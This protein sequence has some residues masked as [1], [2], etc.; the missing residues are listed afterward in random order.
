MNATSCAAMSVLQRTSSRPP[1]AAA[2]TQALDVRQR[3]DGEPADAELD[4]VL[5]RRC[6]RQGRCSAEDELAHARDP[7]LEHVRG[8]RDAQRRRAGARQRR[9]RAEGLVAARH[10][11]VAGGRA[12]NPEPQRLVGAAA[13]ARVGAEHRQLRERRPRAAAAPSS[14]TC[15]RPSRR[16]SLSVH[17]TA[18]T[19]SAVVTPATG[20]ASRS[21][22]PKVVV[23]TG[24]P[25]AGT[26]PRA[27]R[28]TRCRH[29]P[30]RRATWR[31]RGR[32]A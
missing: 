16:R 28:S 3:R 32:Q 23:P 11:D 19:P 14:A 1:R 4:R 5:P 18:A 25:A 27:A 26:A 15:S 29:A 31:T 9:A 2:H 7:R 30:R 17:A 20:P 10:D 13:R 6:A 24:P 21:S 12:A 8:R 22:V